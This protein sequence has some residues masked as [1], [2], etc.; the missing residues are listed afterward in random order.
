MPTSSPL[1]PSLSDPQPCY[2]LGPRDI[3]G[4][5]I[6]T[7]SSGPSTTDND[8][9]STTE[10]AGRG[11]GSASG[12]VSPGLQDSPRNGAGTVDRWMEMEVVIKA[13]MAIGA[14]EV[15]WGF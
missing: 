13:L 11:A 3:I 14:V 7:C 12:G 4:S 1:F 8:N 5:Y 2:Y 15:V 10:E 9:T 6:A